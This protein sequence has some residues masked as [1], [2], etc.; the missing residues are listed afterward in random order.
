MTAISDSD[1][2]AEVARAAG[3]LLLG[4]RAEGREQGK[5]LGLR[6]DHEANALILARLREGDATR[7]LLELLYRPAPWP[8]ARRAQRRRQG[9]AAGPKAPPSALHPQRQP[10][11][12]APVRP[13]RRSPSRSR[14]HC[15]AVQ[16]AGAQGP[17]RRAGLDPDPRAPASPPA[18]PA[19]RQQSAARSARPVKSRVRAGRRAQRN[20]TPRLSIRCVHWIRAGRWPLPERPVASM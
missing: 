5:A 15:R 17:A 20:R 10:S 11:S 4:I 13:C 14:K 1:L 6:G 16:A 3:D 19:A 8:G 7:C 12:P 9:P 18:L 2:A